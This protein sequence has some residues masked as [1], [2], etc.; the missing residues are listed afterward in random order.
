MM[1][2]FDGAA[3][4]PAKIT[5]SSKMMTPFIE[6]A[7]GESD[8]GQVLVA[9]TTDGVCA[10]LFGS[11]AAQ[12]KGDLA[13]RFPASELELNEPKVKSQLAKVV[14]FIK[15]PSRGLDLKLDMRG[16]PFQ[17][18][19]W[20]ELC[21]IPLGAKVTYSDLAR[22]IGMPNGARAIA[23]ACASN[24]IALAVPC[25]RVVRHDGSLSGY[26]WGIERKQTLI[27]KEARA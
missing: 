18:R 3:N 12:L 19:V 2:T 17:R 22:K 1:K 23:S 15:S 10:I 13:G 6:Y 14:Q 9:Q 25:H 16:T 24:H 5:K 21:R 4:R 7:V 8:L 20:E 27:D 26:R 11:S